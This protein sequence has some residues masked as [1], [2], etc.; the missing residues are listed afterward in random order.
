MRVRPAFGAMLSFGAS[1][2]AMSAN[3]SATASNT[4]LAVTLPAMATTIREGTYPRRM[5]SRS[6]SGSSALMTGSRPA[7][8]QPSG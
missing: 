5:K 1:R 6:L 3:R 4:S 2:G 7:T 8:S